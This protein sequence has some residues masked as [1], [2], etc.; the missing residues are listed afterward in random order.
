MT[1]TGAVAI[2]V[3]DNPTALAADRGGPLASP[4]G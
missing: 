2:P 1:L 3:A 4:S